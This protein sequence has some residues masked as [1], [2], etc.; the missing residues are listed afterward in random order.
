MEKRATLKR[1][2]KFGIRN[3]GF[4]LKNFLNHFIEI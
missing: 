2:D 1:E 3:V 4:H